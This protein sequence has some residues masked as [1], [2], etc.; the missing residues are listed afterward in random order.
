MDPFQ[1]FDELTHPAETHP[2]VTHLET[3]P[4]SARNTA[5]GPCS[6][7]VQP[8]TPFDSPLRHSQRFK[9]LLVQ[10]F[11]ATPTQVHLTTS[12]LPDDVGFGVSLEPIAPSSPASTLVESQE[13]LW[14]TLQPALEGLDETSPA[15][16]RLAKYCQ[17]SESHSF[18][19]FLSLL[20][21]LPLSLSLTVT[22]TH[23]FRLTDAF[24]FL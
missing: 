1:D 23:S 6:D 18:S 22:H 4:I 20:L 8:S 17:V 21:S 11:Q 13:Q 10:Q 19:P 16:T 15:F 5:A 2:A 14:D 3:T 12:S 9:H 7:E 24:H